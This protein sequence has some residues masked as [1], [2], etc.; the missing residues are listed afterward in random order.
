MRC[1]WDSLS[2]PGKSIANALPVSF[3]GIHD[4]KLRAGTEQTLSH[5]VLF[6]WVVLFCSTYVS[7]LVKLFYAVL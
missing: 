6:Y 2:L 4:D 3:Q 1:W 7:F 5:L